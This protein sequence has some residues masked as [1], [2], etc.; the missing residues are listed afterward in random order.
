VA[1]FEHITCPT[2]MDAPH[3]A[4]TFPANWIVLRIKVVSHT[5]DRVLSAG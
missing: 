5:F 3:R 1:H 2:G 4:H